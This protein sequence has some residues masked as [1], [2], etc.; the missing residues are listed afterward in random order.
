MGK[1]RLNEAA[2]HALAWFEKANAPG[3]DGCEFLNED[4]TWPEAEAIE[5][6]LHAALKLGEKRASK[7][8]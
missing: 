5:L 2:M 4:G 3:D 6:E 7:T 8:Q 1:D